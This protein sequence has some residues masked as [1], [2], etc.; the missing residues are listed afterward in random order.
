MSNVTSM[1]CGLL[2]APEAVT[3]MLALCSPTESRVGSAAISMSVGAFP[4]DE[5]ITTQL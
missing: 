1:L 4:L 2:A 5:L 3:V